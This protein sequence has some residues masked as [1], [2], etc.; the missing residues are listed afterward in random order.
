V[1]GRP[2]HDGSSTDR[3]GEEADGGEVLSEV[4]IMRGE[5]DAWSE[6]DSLQN[7]DRFVKSEDIAERS[8]TI[9][10]AERERGRGGDLTSIS[11]SGYRSR[12]HGRRIV[13]NSRS[14]SGHQ[15]HRGDRA[16]G[17]VQNGSREATGS[18]GR[19]RLAHFE[20]IV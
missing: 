6:T 12:G 10:E 15:G 3:E 14:G 4:E 5:G 11:Q 8:G 13:R 1:G 2:F 17:T 16:E 19:A 20:E 9:D 18:E 7:V